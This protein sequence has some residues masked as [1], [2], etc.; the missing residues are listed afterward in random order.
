M[1]K[2]TFFETL[3]K[4]YNNGARLQ[5]KKTIENYI[6]QSNLE[7]ACKDIAEF[8]YIQYTSINADAMAGILEMAIKHK[9]EI[10]QVRFP[11]NYLFR[12]TVIK[13]SKD[14]YDCFMEEAIEPF[15]E[16]KNEEESAEYYTELLVV[17]INLN[18]YFFPQY[19]PCIKGMDFNG[20]FSH[21]DIAQGISQIHTSDYELMNDVVEKYNTIIGRRDI[22][23]DLEER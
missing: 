6:E 7:E 23:A 22:L 8:I 17:A 19:V 10:A 9:P 14:I 3:I 5:I 16:S 12:L 11:E 1:N 18:D 4:H 13:G 2:D 15:L 20:A 21:N